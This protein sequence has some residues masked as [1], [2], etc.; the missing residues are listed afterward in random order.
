MLY[1]PIPSSLPR[2]TKTHTQFA[3]NND[4]DL[5]RPR[6]PPGEVPAPALQQQECEGLASAKQ[7]KKKTSLNSSKVKTIFPPPV[8]GWIHIAF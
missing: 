4:N 6:E 8:T 7:R 2:F 1:F 5:L 3:N